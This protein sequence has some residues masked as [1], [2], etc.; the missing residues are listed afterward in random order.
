MDAGSETLPPMIERGSYVPWS[1][2]FMRYIERKKETRMFLKNSI[3]NGPYVLKEIEDEGIHQKH[4]KIGGKLKMIFQGTDLSEQERH[5]RLMNEFNKFTS[6]AGE[7]L[8]SVYERFSRLINNMD[9]NKI[10]RINMAINTKFLNSL[11]PEWSKYVTSARLTKKLKD[12]HYVANT[13]ASSS[14]SLSPHAYYVTHPPLMIGYDDDYQG[15]AIYDDQEDSLTTKSSNCVDIQSK[16]VGNNGRYVS[17]IADTQGDVARNVNAQ[18]NTRNAANVQRIPRTT[19]TYANGHNVQCYN[20]NAIGH[21]ARDCLK[22]RND[23]LLAN[24]FVVEELEELCANV[25]MMAQIQ[26]RQRVN[27]NDHDQRDV[28]SGCSKHMTGNLKPLKNFVE[29]FMG[30]ILFGNDHFEAITGYRDYVHGNATICH[31]YYVEG[32]GCNLF[33]VGVRDSNLY[34]ISISDMTAS[35]PVCL[36]SKA[37][38]T[39]SWLRHR[40]LS[41]LNFVT[42]NQLTKK[43]LVDGLPKFKYNKDHMCSASD[44][45]IQED[46]ANLDENTFINLF[47][48]HVTEEAESSLTNQDPSNMHKFYQLHRSTNKWSKAHP[49]EQVIGDPTKPVMTRS[50]L[51]TDAEA[52]MYALIM[53]TTKPKNIKEA[54]QDHSS[55]ESMQDEL[56]QLERLKV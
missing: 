51:N 13:Y 50:R 36:M 35:S 10:R 27:K 41:H 38:S 54:M 48:S 2:Q 25:G 16:N 8:T 11:Q 17:R 31:V 14:S 28:D 18:R 15:E 47:C 37:T 45:S 29:K 44:E 55:I 43:G 19:A 7:S 22:P 42:I 26:F 53:S 40:G 56:H 3:K 9:Q 4:L 6:K 33:L 23:F 32:V 5:S 34:T 21:Y 12:D 20:C 1:S 52:C 39:K 49:L 46:N 24:A 30:T